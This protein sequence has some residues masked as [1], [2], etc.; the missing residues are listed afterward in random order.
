MRILRLNIFVNCIFYCCGV[1]FD[2][3]LNW[4][5]L[6]LEFRAPGIFL[7]VIVITIRGPQ[8]EVC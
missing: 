8:K 2:N 6:K 7:M 5:L 3:A 4:I 1:G